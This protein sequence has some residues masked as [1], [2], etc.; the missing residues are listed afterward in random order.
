MFS[1]SVINT[2]ILCFLL[3]ESAFI[4]LTGFALVFSP[5]RHPACLT[6]T[7]S[8]CGL[9]THE[10]PTY[11]AAFLNS[12]WSACTFNMGPKTCA[13]GHRDFS[14]LASGWCSIMALGY[15]DYTKGGHLI[16]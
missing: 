12:I 11:V 15:F 7:S 14:N 9:S 8:I 6:I 16:L 5:T 4:R 10:I 13:L 1:N 2:A 3:Y